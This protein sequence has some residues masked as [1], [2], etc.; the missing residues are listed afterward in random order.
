MLLKSTLALSLAFSASLS[1][2]IS[3]SFFNDSRDG[4]FYYKDPKPTTKKEQAKK[5]D[6]KQSIIS[7][8]NIQSDYNKTKEMMAIAF[9]TDKQRAERY[10]AEE[11]Y[12]KNIPYHKLDELSADEYRR[13]LDT[14]RNIAVA[15]PNKEFVKVY[16]SLQKFWVDKSERFAQTWQI[17]NLENP[18]QMMEKFGTESDD[19]KQREITERKENKEFFSKIKQ[20]GGLL[21]ILEDKYNKSIY[22]RTKKVAEIVKQD[23]GLDYIIYDYYE[24]KQNMIKELNIEKGKLPDTIL[25]YVNHKNKKIYKRVSNGFSSASKIINN[26]KFVFDNAILEKEKH[27]QDR[28]KEK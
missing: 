24:I 3:N 25:M 21:Y 1:N 14:T 2:T 26:T 7:T 9:E 28:L 13:M 17:A 8:S 27:P 18:S 16:A 10:K 12:V 5:E 11:E 15:R 20:H 19:I 6:L 23:T 4:Y 22:E